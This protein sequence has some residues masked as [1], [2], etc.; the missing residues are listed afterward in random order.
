MLGFPTSS[1][2]IRDQAVLDNLPPTPT[3]PCLPR[4]QETSP[5]A[6]V[7]CFFCVFLFPCL[8][9]Q[10]A[11]MEGRQTFY[12]D[13]IGIKWDILCH[14]QPMYYFGS[15]WNCG[16]LQIYNS[17]QT[18]NSMITHWVL[19]YPILGMVESF[20]Q[21]YTSI[22]KLFLVEKHSRIGSSVQPCRKMDWSWDGRCADV[23]CLRI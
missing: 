14:Q 17:I 18:R 5:E 15:V 20:Y 22:Y 2:Q 9:I 6:I 11:E 1:Q 4:F 21:I 12:G 23:R 19:G 3:K 16:T 10:S 13:V 7:W 8:G